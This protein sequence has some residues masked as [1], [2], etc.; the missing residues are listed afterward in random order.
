MRVARDAALILWATLRDRVVADVFRLPGAINDLSSHVRASLSVSGAGV[1][2]ASGG[3]RRA[4][5]GAS[6]NRMHRLEQLQATFNE[7]PCM[8]AYRSGRFAGEPDLVNAQARWPVFGPGA[9][10]AGIGATFSFPVHVGDVAFG[11]L[12]CY[13]V[14]PGAL[15]PTQISMGELSAD[16]AADLILHA[17]M[18][19]GVDAVVEQM[20]L[21]DRAAASVEQASGMTAA[22]LGISIPRSLELLRE[23]ARVHHI[24]LDEVATRVIDGRLQIGP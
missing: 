4:V 21:G 6:D 3:Q 5:L 14:R 13:R 1:L 18:G 23:H 10:A 2:V 8:D 22:R 15:T 9:L 24:S 16:I 11:A 7:G 19:A 12:D 20:M 17:Q